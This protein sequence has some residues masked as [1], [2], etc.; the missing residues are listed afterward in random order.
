MEEVRSLFVPILVLAVFASPGSGSAAW[1]AP[2]EPNPPGGDGYLVRRLDIVVYPADPGFESSRR[3]WTLQREIEFFGGYLW[4]HSG[5]RLSV[6][7]RITVV[8]RALEPEEFREQGRP[9]GFLLD[10]S[11]RV[12]EDLR[13]IPNVSDLL[14]LY[15]PPRDRPPGLAGRTFSGAFASSIPLSGRYFE[16]DGFS[17]PLHLVMVHEYLHQLGLA[18]A[19]IRR[20]AGFLDPDLAGRP[21]APGC[22]DRAGA[23]LAMRSVLRFDSACGPV[24]WKALDPGEG[25]WV[26]R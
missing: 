2:A 6:D 20:P 26:A 8:H 25:T 7:S 22:L 4:R 15:D 3:G 1:E 24:D 17:R 14:I 21:G 9:F 16:D 10:R 18:F 13:G 19:R 23:D 12:E 5:R 11:S